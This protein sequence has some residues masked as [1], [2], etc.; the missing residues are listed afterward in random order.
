M[1]QIQPF[2]AER[3]TDLRTVSGHCSPFQ[4]PDKISRAQTHRT[5]CDIRAAPTISS[6]LQTCFEEVFHLASILHLT[7][8]QRVTIHL[9][10]L[11]Y[12]YFGLRSFLLAAQDVHV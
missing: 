5:R 11:T 3:R 2:P 4:V 12:A 1:S 7:A 9:S 8:V 6:H 10:S